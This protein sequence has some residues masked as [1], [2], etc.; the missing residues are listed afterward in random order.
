MECEFCIQRRG[1]CKLIFAERST[2]TWRLISTYL[3]NYASSLV[4]STKEPKAAFY[5]SPGIIDSELRM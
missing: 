2:N 5:T 3:V 4:I 1:T